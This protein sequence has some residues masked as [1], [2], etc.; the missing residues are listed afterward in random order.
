MYCYC[1]HVIVLLNQEEGISC[2]VGISRKGEDRYVKA[3]YRSADNKRVV[4]K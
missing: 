4:C 1:A 2:L 3:Q